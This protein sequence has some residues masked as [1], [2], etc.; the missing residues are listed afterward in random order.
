MNQISAFIGANV[1]HD[2]YVIHFLGFRL[3]HFDCSYML[4]GE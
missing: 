1:L 4:Y 2:D 3:E